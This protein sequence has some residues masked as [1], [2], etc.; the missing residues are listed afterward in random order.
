MG[1]ETDTI[2]QIIALLNGNNELLSTD[3]AGQ[4]NERNVQT[5]YQTDLY[6]N[7]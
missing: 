1:N 2:K 5:M 6:L 4:L 7:K 3:Q